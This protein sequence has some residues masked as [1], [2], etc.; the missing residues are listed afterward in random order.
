MVATASDST[1]SQTMVTSAQ[2]SLAVT[3]T[4]DCS[5]DMNAV[6]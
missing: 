5:L 6:S 1:A 4:A 3:E 2:L